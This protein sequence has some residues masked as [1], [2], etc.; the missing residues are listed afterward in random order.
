MTNTARDRILDV[1]DRAGTWLPTTALVLRTG[2]SP[3]NINTTLRAMVTDGFLE[4]RDD[5]ENNRRA[6][7]RTR[8]PW[9]D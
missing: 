7:W 9:A 6:E 3:V 5:P 8:G 2:L 1:L 4:R